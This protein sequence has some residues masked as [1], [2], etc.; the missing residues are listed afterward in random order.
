MEIKLVTYPIELSWLIVIVVIL[1][2]FCEFMDSS[3]GMGYGT[4][5]TPVLLLMGYEAAHIVPAVLISEFATGIVSA[6]CHTWLKNMTLGFNKQSKTKANFKAE[7]VELNSNLKSIYA[8]NGG[9]SLPKK[10]SLMVRM[11]ELTLDTKVICF[12]TLFGI[13]GTLVASIT[14]AF[15]SLNENFK[16]GVKI[17]IG[18]MVFG[19][20][21]LILAFRNKQM[22]FSFKRLISIGAVAGFNKGISGGGYGPLCVSGQILSGREGKNAIASTSLSEGIICFVGATAYILTNVTKSVTSALPMDWTFLGLTPFIIGGAVLSA[23]LAAL[24]TKS[25]NNKWLKVLVGAA[26]ILLGTFSLIKTI[27]GFLGIW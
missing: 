15:Y 26:T 16:F 14:S 5:L 18:I 10:Q 13:I 11:K 1:A 23:P 7:N 22:K 8:V 3:L 6:L 27:L 20:G 2:F 17:Y 9:I 25:V 24:T 21:I 4:T 12:L 19:M